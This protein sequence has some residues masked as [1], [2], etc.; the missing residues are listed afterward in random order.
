MR[1]GQ[2]LVT[3]YDRAVDHEPDL[4]AQSRGR[5]RTVY[6]WPGVRPAMLSERAVVRWDFSS[7]MVRERLLGSA[8]GLAVARDERL[9]LEQTRQPRVQRNT[10]Q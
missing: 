9:A 1:Q 6:V 10:L 3:V 8:L 5:T 7:G 2:L 4:P